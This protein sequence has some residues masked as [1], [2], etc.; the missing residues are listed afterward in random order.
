MLMKYRILK[1]T[2]AASLIIAAGCKKSFLDVPPQGDLTEEL[3]L[4]DPDAAE[5]LVGGVYNTH[6]F[7]GFGK[8]NVG[9]LWEISNDIAS[10]D[11]DKGSTPG[12]FNSGGVGD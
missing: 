11:A 3:A 5:K 8:T 6:Y 12:D 2:M 4:K 9:F 1:I 10:D 7:G